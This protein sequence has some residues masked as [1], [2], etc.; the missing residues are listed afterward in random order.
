[1]L[2]KIYNHIVSTFKDHTK[3]ISKATTE[4]VQKCQ[5]IQDS[6]KNRS[7]SYFERKKII[8]WLI[9]LNLGLTPLFLILL[10]FKK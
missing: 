7:K 4:T 1:M 5:E 3:L 6:A 10:Y 8:D 2:D 9:F